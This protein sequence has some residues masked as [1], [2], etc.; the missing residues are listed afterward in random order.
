MGA[1]RRCEFS[2]G[3]FVEPITRWE[4]PTRLGFS[5]E[6]QPPPMEEWS[7]YKNLHPRHLDGYFR[8]KR[9]EF[10]IVALPS[11]RTRLEGSTWYELDLSPGE[12]WRL[13]SDGLIHAIHLRVL[14]HI[15]RETEAS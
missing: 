12:Y 4:P 13:W 11:G 14:E 7:P 1:I 9:G 5:V 10:R 2:T 3:P 15:K 6:S 8:S